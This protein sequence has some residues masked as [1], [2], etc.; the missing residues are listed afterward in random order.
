MNKLTTIKIIGLVVLLII[1]LPMQPNHHNLLVTSSGIPNSALNPGYIFTIGSTGTG[2]GEFDRPFGITINETHVF[3]A[4]TY[5]HRVQVFDRFGNFAYKFGSYGSGDGQFNYTYGIAVNDSHIFVTDAF[6]SR[7]QIFDHAGNFVNKFGSYGS[8]SGQLSWPYGI[9]LN[10]SHIF[11]AERGNN[12]VQIFDLAGNNV[13]AFGGF[14]RPYRVAVNNSHIFVLDTFNQRIRIFDLSINYVDGFTFGLGLSGL[15]VTDDYIIV[16]DSGHEW[17]YILDHGLIIIKKIQDI[18]S[19][20]GQ[21]NAPYGIEADE[22]YLYITDTT[23]NRIQVFVKNF[24]PQVTATPNLSTIGLSWDPP[25]DSGIH[26]VSGYRVYKGL[27]PEESFLVHETPLTT[28]NDMDVVLNET[29]FYRVT[30]LTAGGESICSNLIAAEIVNQVTVTDTE[31]VTDLE[32]DT[33]VTTVKE[34]VT[35]KETIIEIST[36]TENVTRTVYDVQTLPTVHDTKTVVETSTI[37]DTTTEIST[38]TEES[39][40]PWIG[41][42]IMLPLITRLIRRK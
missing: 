28:F 19:G 36:P 11:V 1:S 4:D 3:V 35:Q 42:F 17:I 27:T 22:T 33:I 13:S 15:T 20:Y 31:T 12:R 32:T 29:Y 30:A 7:I 14:N 16:A 40:F 24:P 41:F 39:P 34:T 26:P 38:K 37:F 23:N 5:N 6:N 25:A 9:S 8:S 18:G 2:D 10:N 21:F